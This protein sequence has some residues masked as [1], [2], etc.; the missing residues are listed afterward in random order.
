MT[1]RLRLRQFREDDVEAMHGCFTD[2]EFDALLE[3]AALHQADRDRARGAA[4]HRLYTV[5]LSVFGRSPIKRPIAVSA[6][7]TITMAIS[8]I[9]GWPLV[10]SSI[11]HTGGRASPLRRSRR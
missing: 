8:A 5:L 7:S 9:S 10:T 4:L 11:P 2:V 3:Y 1:P 6:W